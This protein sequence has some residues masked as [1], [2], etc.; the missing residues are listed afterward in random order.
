VTKNNTVVMP[1]LRN[2]GTVEELATGERGKADRP[3]LL[4]LD[5]EEAKR[6][7]S[8]TNPKRLTVNAK[9]STVNGERQTVNGERRTV[10]DER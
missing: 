5:L 9:R 8:P 7:A 2:R 4:R 3:G 6:D 1:R 10:N